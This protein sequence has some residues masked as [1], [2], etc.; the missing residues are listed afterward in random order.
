MPTMQLKT[1]ALIALL[2]LLGLIGTLSAAAALQAEPAE[3]AALRPPGPP[4]PGEP[5]PARRPEADPAPEITFITSSTPYCAQLEPSSNDCYINWELID[6][7]S[8]PAPYMTHMTITIDSRV[9]AT[10]RGFFQDQISVPST[11]QGPGFQVAC[12]ALGTDGT[13]LLGR[14]YTFS[15]TARDSSGLKAGNYGVV[16]CP[17]ANL[18]HMPLIL[19]E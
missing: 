3:P 19:R 9:R 14:Y 2:L 7:A 18:L 10:S 17:G 6:V 5:A 4:L 11:M 13:P 8:A 15:I 1:G 12:G 16:A